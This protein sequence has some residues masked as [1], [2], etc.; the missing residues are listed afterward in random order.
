MSL[1]LEQINLLYKGFYNISVA[2]IVPIREASFIFSISL[3][4]CSTFSKLTTLSV[5]N[6][7]KWLFFI[8][9]EFIAA[10]YA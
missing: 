6:E 8:E 5:K 4:T 1:F 10:I 2:Y 7:Y 3:T 9:S